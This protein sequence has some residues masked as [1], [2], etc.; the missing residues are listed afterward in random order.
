M[1]AKVPSILKNFIALTV[2]VTNVEHKLSKAGKPYAIALAAVPQTND[3]PP[4]TLRVVA[5]DEVGELLAD[6]LHTLSGR[7]GY[8]EDR[9]GRG[10]LVLY[11][12]KIEPPPSD[13]RMRNF[14]MLTLR[15]G[16]EPNARYSSAAR[17]WVRLRA[18]LGMGKTADD[19]EYKPSLWLTVKAFAS[20]EGDER[21]P[22]AI[23]ALNKGEQA[24]FSGHLA[25]EVYKDKGNLILFAYKVEKLPVEPETVEE[26]EC[27]V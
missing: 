23:A 18:F 20:K 1:T 9:E 19:Q 25:W 14:A 12:T 22:A 4:L 8:E 11:P 13:G 10:V 17:F 27:P 6:G 16:A 2:Q 24:T 7:L 5:L 26:Q 21:L 15:V 3:D